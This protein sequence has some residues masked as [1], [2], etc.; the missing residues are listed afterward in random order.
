MAR[1]RQI[2]PEFF[3]SEDIAGLEWPA[4]VL[5]IGLW[6]LAAADGRLLDRPRR[7]AAELFPYDHMD[8][9]VD[10]LLGMLAARELILR[11]IAEGKPCIQ[12]VNFVKHQKPHP[13]EPGSNLPPP[14]NRA[15]VFLA[16]AHNPEFRRLGPVDDHSVGQSPGSP[17]QVTAENGDNRTEPG[18]EGTS[19]SGSLGSGSLENG[20]SALPAPARSIEH[21]GVHLHL[22]VTGDGLRTA[23]GLVRA[24]CIPGAVQWHAPRSSWKVT[25]PLAE[26]LRDDPA[27]AADTLPTMFRFFELA[28]FGR[29]DA[30]GK[31]AK[32]PSF[33]FA[34][35]VD[36]FTAL[37]EDI[38]GTTPQISTPAARAGP[39]RDVR[40]GTIRAEDHPHTKE[41]RQEI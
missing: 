16:P 34:C 25:D 5:F 15:A 7:I 12:I 24:L 28:K 38:R 30:E 27:A 19:R 17:G 1:I 2:K 8:E 29:I 11:Y 3:K 13:K 6:T 20:K 36:R 32:D 22:P 18:E 31:A 9:Q 21:R 41:G 10:I 40:V 14:P 23:Y 39:A 26:A 4:R 37:R 35:W 33:G